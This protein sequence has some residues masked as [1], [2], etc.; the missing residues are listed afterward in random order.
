MVRQ[1]PKIGGEKVIAIQNGRV[2]MGRSR[3]HSKEQE[4]R[5]SLC[6]R[7]C[8]KVVNVAVGAWAYLF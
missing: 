1:Y 7:R 5:P 2:P 3:V 8:W 4:G 6:A